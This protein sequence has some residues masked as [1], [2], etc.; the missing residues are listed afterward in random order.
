MRTEGRRDVCKARSS[1]PGRVPN[2]MVKEPFLSWIIKI[3]RNPAI[4]AKTNLLGE[5]AGQNDPAL[6]LL[7]CDLQNV[8]GI[9]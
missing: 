2:P 3:V 5:F 1:T 4:I 8:T 9:S 7:T 6:S